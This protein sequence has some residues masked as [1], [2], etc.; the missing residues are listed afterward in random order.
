MR[1]VAVPHFVDPIE[2]LKLFID[3]V[4]DLGHISQKRGHLMKKFHER[5]NTVR[6]I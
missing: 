2:L 1:S 5:K 4:H 6:F 3:N